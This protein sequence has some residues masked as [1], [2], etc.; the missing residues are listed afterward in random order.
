LQRIVQTASSGI[1]AEHRTPAMVVHDAPAKKVVAKLR[2]QVQNLHSQI[3][4]INSTL[5]EL[6]S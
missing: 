2:G 5:N 3:N 1:R 6:E 4:E